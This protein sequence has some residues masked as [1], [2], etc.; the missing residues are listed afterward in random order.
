MKKRVDELPAVLTC[1]AYRRE[2][3]EE[4]EGML[5]T[6]REHHPGWPVVVGRG[7]VEGFSEPTLEVES[8]QGKSHWTLPV[9]FDLDGSENDFLNIV[10]MKG[11]W[12]AQV[13]HHFGQLVSGDRN[14]LVW[15][16]ADAR[17]NGPLDIELEPDAEVIAAAWWD[18]PEDSGYG[19]IC[20][21]LLL[22]QGARNGT[23]AAILDQW[24]GMCLSHIKAPP[25]QTRPWPDDEQEAL[26]EVLKT[27]S[28]S[29]A[30]YVSIK[31]APDKYIGLPTE[32]GKEVMR[33]G[34]VDH[35]YMSA[36]MRLPEYRDRN[37]PPPEEYRRE[38][39]IGTPIPNVNW[40]IPEDEPPDEAR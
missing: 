21:G 19:H 29:D 3:F 37:W 40:T 39:E 1:F 11:W 35:W 5:R 7:P 17:F 4:M 22:L 31:L 23:I 36:K 24:S 20:S 8:P 13:W 14:R 28:D 32:G 25:P 6:I 18:D 10:R 9:S 30:E 26:T 27:F 2:Y 12:I 34:L 38:A 15:S 33:R 16:D